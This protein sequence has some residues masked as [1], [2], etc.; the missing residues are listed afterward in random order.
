MDQSCQSEEGTNYVVMV[1]EMEVTE[2]EVMEWEWE[3]DRK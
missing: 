2:R 1:F 3:V